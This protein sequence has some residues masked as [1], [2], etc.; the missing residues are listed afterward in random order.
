MKLILIKDQIGHRG[1]ALWMLGG[2][3]TNWIVPTCLGIP[4]FG[5][6]Q[7]DFQVETEGIQFTDKPVIFCDT[8]KNSFDKKEVAGFF[9]E[10]YM[11]WLIAQHRYAD[12][13]AYCRHFESKMID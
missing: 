12:A 3:C 8:S 13:E 9:K 2:G 7:E 4:N 11:E 10:M 5:C 6:S 1:F